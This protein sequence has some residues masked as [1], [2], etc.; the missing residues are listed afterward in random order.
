MGFLRSYSNPESLRRNNNP[1]LFNKS[2]LYELQL[3]QKSKY[4]TERRDRT[5]KVCTYYSISLWGNDKYLQHKSFSNYSRM[6][7][8]VARRIYR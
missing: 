5:V 4:P 7:V 8:S 2:G 1:N 3:L 6:S